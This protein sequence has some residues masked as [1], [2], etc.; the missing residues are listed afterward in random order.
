MLFCFRRLGLPILR[1][2]PARTATTARLVRC[3]LALGL[4]LRRLLLLGLALRLRF[5]L[6]VLLAHLVLA[7]LAERLLSA[8]SSAAGCSALAASA[9]PGAVGSTLSLLKISSGSASN[10][11]SSVVLRRGRGFEEIGARSFG[12]DGSF[13]RALPLRMT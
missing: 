3:A 4:R 5:S 12:I 6:G 10:L 7:A 9:S 2:I 13:F 11:S 1:A 8:S